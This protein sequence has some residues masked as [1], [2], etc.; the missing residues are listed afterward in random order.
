VARGDDETAP[1]PGWPGLPEG[2]AAA[3]WHA[4]NWQRAWRQVEP[5]VLA[6]PQR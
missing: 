6:E 4:F 1:A 2:W 3:P 5:Q